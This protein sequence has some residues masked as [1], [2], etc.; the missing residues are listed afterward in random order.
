MKTRSCY[1]NN[2]TPFCNCGAAVR[3][4]RD[5]FVIDNC[6]GVVRPPRIVYCK[7]GVFHRQI[8]RKGATFEVTI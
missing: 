7:D 4:G 3:A 5:I 6:G 1:N 2:R 8:K